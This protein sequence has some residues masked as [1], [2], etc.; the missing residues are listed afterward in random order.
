MLI[1]T[2]PSNTKI[3]LK[4]LAI[5][6]KQEFRL[7]PRTELYV[8]PSHRASRH[9]SKGNAKNQM[10]IIFTKTLQLIYVK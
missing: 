2:S 6:T 1:I 4:T 7:A 10:N 9:Y 5:H 8:S 3:S